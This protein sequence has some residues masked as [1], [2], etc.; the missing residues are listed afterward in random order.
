[1][2]GV[3]VIK[4]ERHTRAILKIILLS[5]LDCLFLFFS[6]TVRKLE[7][8]SERPSTTLEEKILW[9]VKQS[10]SEILV[11]NSDYVFFIKFVAVFIAF[12]SSPSLN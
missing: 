2:I 10:V 8:S 7:K 1:M 3:A 12:P 6:K 4:E 9:Q 11:D 5:S